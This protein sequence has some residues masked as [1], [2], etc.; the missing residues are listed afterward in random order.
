MG[1][2]PALAKITPPQHASGSL[3]QLWTLATNPMQGWPQ[4]VYEQPIYRSRIF[5]REAVFVSDPDLVREVLVTKDVAFH[6]AEAMRRALRPALGDGILTA[7]GQH[8]RWQRRA[9]A[10]IFRHERILSFL[11]A[12]VAAAERCVERLLAHP[13]GQT[14]NLSSEMMQTTFD[15]IVETMLGGRHG[16]DVHR[17]EQAITDYVSSTNWA[18]AYELLSAP[19]WLPYPGRRKA[20]RARRYLRAEAMRLA[21]ECRANSSGSEL[22]SLLLQ[23]RDPESGRGMTDL[24]IAD[25]LL[26]FITAGHETTALALTWTFYLWPSTAK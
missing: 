25:N 20:D 13:P 3:R 9:V 4:A 26:T 12:M 24:E 2:A 7:E 1:S 21:A 6:K 18:F 14:V 10:P 5:G 22:I 15:V 8:W 11:P 16:I 19:H 23:A 17:I